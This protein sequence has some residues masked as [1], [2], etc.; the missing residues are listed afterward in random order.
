[1]QW[2]KICRHLPNVETAS[3]DC[4]HYVV[5]GSRSVAVYSR[6]S[7]A[8]ASIV[9]ENF[10]EISMGCAV[11]QNHA[12]LQ[13]PA[14]S[15]VGSNSNSR[16]VDLNIT[17]RRGAI[18]GI[19]NAQNVGALLRPLLTTENYDSDFSSRKILLVAQIFIRGQQ[20]IKAGRLS[21]R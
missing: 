20:N 3:T 13:P 2:R 17:A 7:S 4:R 1:M 11:P 19:N 21:S 8:G 15:S 10:S 12:D 5:V 18:D 16:N 9:K 14:T 6:L